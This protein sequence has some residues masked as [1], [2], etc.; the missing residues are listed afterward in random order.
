M[1][2]DKL[3]PPPVVGRQPYIDLKLSWDGSQELSISTMLDC[4]VNVPV[5][6]HSFIDRYKVLGVLRCHA[7]GLTMANGSE[8]TTNAGR[9]NTY[10]CT[11]GCGG[12]F[13]WESFDISALQSAHE[14]PLP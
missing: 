7:H 12:H 2:T 1:K 6:S 11:L 9:A 5:T 14:I 13:S 8:S 10:A 4:G 3:P